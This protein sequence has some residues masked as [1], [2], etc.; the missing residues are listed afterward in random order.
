MKKVIF[1]I[2]PIV[3]VAVLMF[4]GVSNADTIGTP[5]YVNAFVYNNSSIKVTWDNN[6]AGATRFTIQRK[7]DSGNFVTI[8]TVSANVSSYTDTS[9]SNGHT[10][11]YRVFATKGSE[12][13]APRRIISGGISL[14]YRADR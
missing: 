11:V 13:G 12:L 6:V 4:S 5:S 14:P 10:Y 3:A 9:I 7:T 1:A 8:A 2:I